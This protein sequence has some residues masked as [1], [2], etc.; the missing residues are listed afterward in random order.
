MERVSWDVSAFRGNTA[1]ISIEDKGSGSWGHI[2]V[3]DVRF[4]DCRRTESACASGYAR[5]LDAATGA[6]AGARC[7]RFYGEKAT[8]HDAR[9]ACRAS[10]PRY[11]TDLA[12]VANADENAHLGALLSSPAFRAAASSS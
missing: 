7:F 4:E 5:P 11:A 2:N 10:E 1:R 9:D 12:T 6:P 8:W 3:D